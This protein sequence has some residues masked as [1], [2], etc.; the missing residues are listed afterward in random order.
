MNFQTLIIAG[1]GSIGG[2]M[3]AVGKQYLPWF[4]KVVAV[5]RETK[6]PLLPDEAAVEV[7]VGDVTDT[8]FLERLVRGVPAPVLLL[9]LCAGTDHVRLRKMLGGLAVAYLDSASCTPEGTDEY[10]FSR[11]MP[12]TLTPVE[13][14]YPHWL[15]WGI[16]PGVVELVTRMLLRR[17]GLPAAEA[18][19][20]IFEYDGLQTANPD[21]GTAVGWCPA[22]LVEEM[23]ISPSLEV[24]EGGLREG[25]AAGGQ[26]VL[27]SWANETVACRVVGHEDIWN[28][29]QLLGVGSARFVYGLSPRVMSVLESRDAPAAAAELKVPPPAT[30]VL[31]LERVAVQVSSS[32]SGAS[33]TLLWE[34]DHERVWKRLGVNGVQFQ[35]SVSLW[36]ALNMLQHTRFGTLPGTW[37]ASNHPFSE[38]DWRE[39]ESAMSRLGMAWEEADHSS[40]RLLP[41]L[42]PGRP[43]F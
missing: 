31:G 40:I 14:G 20:T 25:L 5:D 22:F 12:Y 2:S 7:L 11:M 6:S 27:V 41:T 21:H 38:A 39:V 23:L 30:P 29:G 24:E 1:L 18:E 15:C 13:S 9:N 16:N 37:C 42:F 10:R 3:F 36:L 8:S 35:T 34:T 43:P 4:A 33:R 26:P 28:L 19:V 17:M 32:S